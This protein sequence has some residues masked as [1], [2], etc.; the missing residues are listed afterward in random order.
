MKSPSKIPGYGMNNKISGVKPVNPLI[1][2]VV[3]D[4]MTGKLEV[5]NGATWQVLTDRLCL[6]CGYAEP[7]HGRYSMEYSD[8]HKFIGDNLEYLEYKYEQSIK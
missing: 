6:V 5:F 2:M 3:F 8:G 1:G 4:Y 7:D